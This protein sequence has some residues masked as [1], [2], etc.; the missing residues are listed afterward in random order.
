[1]W[2]S[3]KLAAGNVP[4]LVGMVAKVV[5]L[6]ALCGAIELK[7]FFNSVGSGEGCQ[8]LFFSDLMGLGAGEGDNS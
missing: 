1:M 3:A 7:S 5:A 6:L 8:S 2:M 4:A